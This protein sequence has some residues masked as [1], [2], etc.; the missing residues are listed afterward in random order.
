[1]YITGRMWHGYEK[2]N[3]CR[4]TSTNLLRNLKVRWI[5]W[6]RT[7]LLELMN[8]SHSHNHSHSDHSCRINYCSCISSRPAHDVMFLVGFRPI[9]SA[10]MWRQARHWTSASRTSKHRSRKPR[11]L[12][13]WHW[14]LVNVDACRR[15]LCTPRIRDW[16]PP[17]SLLWFLMLACGRT[18]SER[19]WR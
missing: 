8:R 15:H 13:C 2:P 19:N 11:H 7:H 3:T 18:R 4:M 14:N 16:S 12:H 9:T 10:K 1:M 17:K 6:Q 5:P